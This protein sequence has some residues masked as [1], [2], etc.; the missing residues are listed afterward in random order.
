MIAK[1]FI[2]TNIYIYALTRS[3]NPN[4]ESKRA[5]AISLFEKLINTHTIVTSTQVLNEFHSNLIKKFKLEDKEA[6][7][8]VEH[9]ILPISIIAPIGFK[10]YS[11]AYQLRSEYNLSFWDSLIVSSG[12]ENHCTTLYSEDMQHNQS[13]KNHLSI[14]NPF[15]QDVKD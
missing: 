1:A 15:E 4:D 3:R 14:I 12:L 9:N 11:L 7:S 13:I 5:V 2:D 6:F 8:I 10:T